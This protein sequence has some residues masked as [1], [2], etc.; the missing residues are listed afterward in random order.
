MLLPTYKTCLLLP[1]NMTTSDEQELGARLR[2]VA[3]R[4]PKLRLR[5]MDREE[6]LRICLSAT[7]LWSLVR[8]PPAVNLS[9]F[10]YNPILY[11]LSFG[12]R[13]IYCPLKQY[14]HRFL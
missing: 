8:S 9:S 12:Q 6:M 5:S 4:T 1:H 13:G 10:L 14:L 11:L 7:S 3:L 2:N